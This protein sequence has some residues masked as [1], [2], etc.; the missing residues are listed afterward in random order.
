MI[1][2][3]CKDCTKRHLHCHSSCD[4][5]KQYKSEVDKANATKSKYLNTDYGFR[6]SILRS[7]KIK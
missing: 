1:R 7:S 6:D 2:V 5:Y 3:P 4:E